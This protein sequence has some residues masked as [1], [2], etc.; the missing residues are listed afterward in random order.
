MIPKK[1]RVHVLITKFVRR[2][3]TTNDFSFPFS[4]Q[5]STLSH[6]SLRLVS[7]FLLPLT[8]TV[9]WQQSSSHSHTHTS[10]LCNTLHICFHRKW[11]NYN[12]KCQKNQ[13]CD[14]NF[15]IVVWNGQV[16]QY[17]PLESESVSVCCVVSPFHQMMWPT[18][19][20]FWWQ[21]PPK[22]RNY[23]RLSG[24]FHGQCLVPFNGLR[25]CDASVDF[26]DSSNCR[27]GT[28]SPQV[29]CHVMW[30][31]LVRPADRWL[32]H[33]WHERSVARLSCADAPHLSVDCRHAC[34][35]RLY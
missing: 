29:P 26:P 2:L 34:G 12:R 22:H 8:L 7:E 19:K 30:D 4:T 16:S 14:Q 13:L 24:A 25:V 21:P 9:D 15:A 1:V 10:A 5:S 27:G 18:L 6:S 32:S 20:T 23:G 17:R 11:S 33:C 3:T 31:Y 35:T 28:V